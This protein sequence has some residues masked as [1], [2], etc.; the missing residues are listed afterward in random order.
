[1][2]NFSKEHKELI[3]VKHLFFFIFGVFIGVLITR[4]SIKIKEKNKA[5]E[6][7]EKRIE[8]LEQHYYNNK[9]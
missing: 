1:M 9:V 2:K 7:N 8:K 4:F 6:L 3:L 5:I